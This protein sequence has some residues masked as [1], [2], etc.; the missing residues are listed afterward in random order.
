MHRTRCGVAAVSRRRDRGGIGRRM[1]SGDRTR[2]ARLA[3]TR[4][5]SHR[6]AGSCSRLRRRTRRRSS[7]L[8]WWARKRRGWGRCIRPRRCL[9]WG[10][11]T[12]VLTGDGP[13]RLHEALRWNRAGSAACC[14]LGGNGNDSH[15][16]V[17]SFHARR[18][19]RSR[20][21]QLFRRWEDNAA[22]PRGQKSSTVSLAEIGPVFAGPEMKVSSRD[23]GYPMKARVPA[24]SWSQLSPLSLV[25]L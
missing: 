20:S 10:C 22:Q 4:W 17:A 3:T 13:F 16:L 1:P 19:A 7:S 8:H 9:L 2:S 11:Q 12:S 24:V 21:L 15:Q 23:G 25:Q 14:G 5:G 6:T 18:P